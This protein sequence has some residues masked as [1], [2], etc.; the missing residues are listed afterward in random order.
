ME[1]ADLNFLI[2]YLE[3]ASF[4]EETHGAVAKPV[5]AWRPMLIY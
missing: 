1:N 5:I 3:C 4:P 2:R